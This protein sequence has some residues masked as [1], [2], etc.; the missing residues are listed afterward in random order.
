MIVST[1]LKCCID[2]SNIN[3]RNQRVRS[4]ILRP[5]F[6]CAETR[7]CVHDEDGTRYNTS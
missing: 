2:F 3:L 7:M 4:M 5:A 1:L 6:V